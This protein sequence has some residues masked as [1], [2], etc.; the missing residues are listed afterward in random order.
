MAERTSYRDFACST[1]Q[2]LEI[3]GEWW[4]LLII[5]DVFFGIHRF[6]D[7]QRRLGVSRSV[8]TNRL[9]RLVD[10][11]ILATREY[12][13]RPPRVEYVLTDKGADLFPVLV[14]LQQWGDRW[15]SPE[16]PVVLRHR[17]CGKLSR[18]HLVCSACGDRVRAADMEAEP[19]PG[20]SD[21]SQLPPEP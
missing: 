4:T 19:G 10:E 8:L 2:S 6:D 11:G 3:V 16:P 5:R 9:N 15:A 20:G 18:P 7:F 14:A 13:S 12:Q 17:G 1:A 21:P